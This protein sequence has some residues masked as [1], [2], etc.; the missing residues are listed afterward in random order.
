MAEEAQKTHV[1]ERLWS[2]Y[3]RMRIHKKNQSELT[4]ISENLQIYFNDTRHS[5]KLGEMLLQK[6]LPQR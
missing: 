2:D 4:V 1:L 5:D 6:Q 3:V